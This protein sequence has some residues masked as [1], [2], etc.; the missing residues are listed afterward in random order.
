[1]ATAANTHWYPAVCTLNT[2]SPCSGVGMS[3]R[4]ASPFSSGR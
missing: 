1:M 2:L 4:P 3:D